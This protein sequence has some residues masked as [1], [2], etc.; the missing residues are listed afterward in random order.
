MPE[1]DLIK[2]LILCGKE[3]TEK[4][5]GAFVNILLLSQ[6]TISELHKSNLQQFFSCDKQHSGYLTAQQE[7]ICV[8]IVCWCVQ[9]TTCLFDQQHV[10]QEICPALNFF[11]ISSVLHLIFLAY[12]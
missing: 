12:R 11:I 4:K 8:Y 9:S 5:F 2:N 6:L 7:Y 3:L 1:V 10:C